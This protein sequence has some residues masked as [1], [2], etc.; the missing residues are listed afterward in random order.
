MN[1]IDKI[2][3]INLDTRKDRREEIEK[4][5]EKM[6]I[7]LEK[8]E[9]FQAIKEKYGM[10]GCSKSHLSVLKLALKNNYENTIIFEDDFQFLVTKEEFHSL[11]KQFF[12]KYKDNFDF[13]YLQYNLKENQDKDHI[14]GYA[15]KTHGAAGYI[16]N[17]RILKQYIEILES[18]TDNLI[19][20]H[21]HWIYACDV[22]WHSL[23]KS[24]E[25]FYFKQRIGK[26]RASFSDIS[27][28]F[29]SNNS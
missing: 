4:E 14:V 1:H 20:T 8:I 27:N 9:R 22:C 7:P 24:G 18:A 19:K 13:C 10:I 26:Q 23:Q 11:L 16:I 5:F 3:Y 12:E 29:E 28:R 2:Y 15:R 21:K 25:S 17:K 6:E